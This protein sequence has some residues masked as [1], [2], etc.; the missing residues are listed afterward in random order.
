VSLECKELQRENE[1]VVSVTTFTLDD[2]QLSRKK[3]IVG[4]TWRGGLCLCVNFNTSTKLHRE[5][6]KWECWFRIHAATR[7]RSKILRNS[8]CWTLCEVD[9]FCTIRGLHGGGDPFGSLLHYDTVYQGSWETNVL[10]QSEEMN[11]T[12]YV[13]LFNTVK[14]VS[15]DIRNLDC[16]LDLLNSLIP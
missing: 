5:R 1:A 8:T 15:D 6:K 10:Y 9:N 11:H 14:R 3:C 4:I 2:G 16:W 13:V 7:W 12:R